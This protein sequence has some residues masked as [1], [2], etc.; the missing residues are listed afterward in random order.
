MEDTKLK[1]EEVKEEGKK[2]I[3]YPFRKFAIVPRRIWRRT[4]SRSVPSAWILMDGYRLM[5]IHYEV[6]A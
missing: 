4:M 3:P 1:I 5:D 2:G 6:A